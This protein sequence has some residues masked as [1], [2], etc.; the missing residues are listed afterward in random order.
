MNSTTFQIMTL[1][2]FLNVK[3][4]NEDYFDTLNVAI[5]LTVINI[6]DITIANT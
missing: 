6:A 5:S 4:S 3:D 2:Y 1:T